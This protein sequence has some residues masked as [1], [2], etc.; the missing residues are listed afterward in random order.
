[1]EEI[2]ARIRALRKE[3]NLSLEQLAQKCGV[4]FSA[5]SRIENGKGGGTY[6]THRRVS[7]ALGVSLAELYRGLEEPEDEAVSIQL[8]SQDAETFKY[9]EKASSVLLTSQTSR[10]Q[11]LPQLI[12]LQPKGRTA[13]EQYQRG[14]E[15]GIL[16]TEGTIE[17]RVG[18]K[19]YALA[20]GGTLYFKASLPHQ[21]MNANRRA[22]KIVSVTTPVAL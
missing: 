8:K 1:M 3:R 5:L 19:K 7:E 22:A 21:F 2:G 9:D 20:K 10:K 17:I 11:M 13:L 18:E 12:L 15:R 6:R 14:T 4:A 16:C